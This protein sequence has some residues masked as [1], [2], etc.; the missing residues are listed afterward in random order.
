MYLHRG[1]EPTLLKAV[2][3]F[4]I[5]A[6][7]GPRQSGKSTLLKRLF[8]PAYEF[9]SFDDPFLREQ[10][11][12]DPNLFLDSHAGKLILDEIQYVPQLLP[13]LKIRVDQSPGQR[14]RYLLT[15]SQQ[16]H[17]MRDLTETLAGRIGLFNLLPFSME[18]LSAVRRLRKYF[19]NSLDAFLYSAL[20]GSYPEPTVYPNI[21]LSNWYASYVQTYLD[22]DVRGLHNVGRLRDFERFLRL[23]AGRCSQILNMSTFAGDIGVSVPTIRH[24]IS[25]LE[26]SR[27]IYLLSPYYQNW[28]KRITKNPKLYFLDVGLVCYLTGIT[29]KDHLLQGPMAGALF[30]NYCVQ[31]IIKRFLTQ[32][33]EPRL[34]Y[35]RTHNQF[36]IDLLIDKGINGV[37]PV[38]IKLTKTPSRQMAAVFERTNHLFPK[39]KFQQGILLCLV[40]QP[41]KLT[42]LVTATSLDKMDGLV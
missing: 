7:S 31:E 29:S 39:L 37:I 26:A 36:E 14:G 25:I 20:R 11:I 3:Q 28:G 12:R 15:G 8:T 32:G 6:L 21:K 2:K 4:R 24:W 1:I 10:A 23:A 41:I 9:A 35:L 16:F 38:E 40:S 13:Y 17:L 30:E 33:K 18:E 42:R 22:R 19:A 34:Y 5:V 27:M